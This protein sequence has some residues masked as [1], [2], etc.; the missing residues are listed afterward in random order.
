IRKY[1]IRDG[2]LALWCALP[3][4]PVGFHV[5]VVD[6]G[7]GTAR[8]PIALRVARGD[9]LIGPDNGLLV[10]AAERLGGVVEARLLENPAYRL[11][12][13]TSTFHGRDVFAPAAA[14]L[15][16]G[17]SF[18]S[19]GPSIPDE[20]V[21]SP[22]PAASAVDGGLATEV[23]YEDTFGNLKLSALVADVERATGGDP[24][25]AT[26]EVTADGRPALTIRWARTFGLVGPGDALLYEDSYGRA[27]IAV[28]QGSAARSLGLVEGTRLLLRR[29]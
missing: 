11:P 5:A 15:A 10:A 20:L 7:V 17:A 1:A 25:S 19:L 29:R 13:V 22:L 9:V 21:P 23:I 24:V 3:Y 12:V 4:A 16:R 18:E 6:P 28:N 26:F 2:A 27:C 14:H 8:R